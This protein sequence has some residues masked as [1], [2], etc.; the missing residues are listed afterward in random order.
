MYPNFTIN[1]RNTPCLISGFFLPAKMLMNW[2]RRSGGGS[3]IS[4]KSTDRR[5]SWKFPENQQPHQS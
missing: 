4:P 3:E 5:I 2:I 1:G